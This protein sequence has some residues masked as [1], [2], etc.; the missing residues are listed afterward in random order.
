MEIYKNLSL[1]SMPFE[2]W[3][4]CVFNDEKGVWDYS[5]YYKVSSMGRVKSLFIDGI[6]S[7][8]KRMVRNETIIRQTK[9]KKGYLRISLKNKK[10]YH[11]PKKMCVHRLVLLCAGVENP[12][13]KTDV[14]H[15]KGIK[16][17]NR[18]S[19]LEWLTRKENIRHSYDNNL[20]ASAKGESQWCSVLKEY[21]VIEIFLSSES[22][23]S[24]SRKYGVT[25]G[26]VSAI[27]CGRNWKWLTNAENNGTKR[28]EESRFAKLSN[29][30]AIL[31]SLSKETSSALAKQY[32]VL[33][34][35]IRAIKTGQN[36]SKI[37]GVK[38]Y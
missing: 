37:T 9:C 7:E 3:Y 19:Q 15:L 20:V 31:V 34:S 38:I 29:K 32:G 23:I 17:D 1:I 12:D 26:V 36:W 16:H 18:L 28:G 24:L 13:K 25:A 8:G 14:N 6:D 4:P 5:Q 21:Q 22:N 10:V 35:T 2:V 11:K 30:Q 33:S 27:K